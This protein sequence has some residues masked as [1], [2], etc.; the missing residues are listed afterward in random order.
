MADN[1]FVACRDDGKDDDGKDGDD[2]GK[3]DDGKDVVESEGKHGKSGGRKV[4]KYGYR[5]W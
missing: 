1:V 5:K 4:W 3:D 2:D